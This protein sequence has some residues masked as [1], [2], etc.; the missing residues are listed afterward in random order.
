MPWRVRAT[1]VSWANRP[2]DAPS[3]FVLSCLAAPPCA[4]PRCAAPPRPSPWYVRVLD[5]TSLHRISL[6]RASEETF[7][8]GVFDA[9][10]G[11]RDGGRTDSS[12]SRPARPRPTL[13]PGRVP[14]RP[15]TPVICPGFEFDRFF[16]FGSEMVG[17]FKDG[18]E[19][20]ECRARSMSDQA[21]SKNLHLRNLSIA[22]FRPRRTKKTLLS[23][24]DLRSINRNPP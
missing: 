1:V 23:S 13:P 2:V 12:A 11:T 7:R 8:T 3:S 6:V 22:D 20:F 21:H 9:L 19:L 24:V 14:P 18:E 10:A 5:S 17:F 4:A 16:F 15:D